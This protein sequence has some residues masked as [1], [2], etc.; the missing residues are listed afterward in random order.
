MPSSR[1]RETAPRLVSSRPLLHEHP[2]QGAT[3]SDAR[4]S[5]PVPC[6]NVARRSRDGAR[7]YASQKAPPDEQRSKERAPACVPDDT[8]RSRERVGATTYRCR[9]GIATVGPMSPRKRPWNVSKEAPRER[10]TGESAKTPRIAETRTFHDVRIR[11]D[12]GRAQSS[13][14]AQNRDARLRERRQGRQRWRAERDGAREEHSRSPASSSHRSAHGV[15]KR[16]PHRSPQNCRGVEKRHGGE[17]ERLGRHTIR[18]VPVTESVDEQKSAARI[19]DHRHVTPG[20]DLARGL[21]R[22]A[23]KGSSQGPGARLV[24]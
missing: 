18:W 24:I 9:S 17:H 7:V 2:S 14:L 22:E 23:R 10:Y 8:A 16:R 6:A 13:S 4:P 1:Q 15:V 11:N 3:E 12:L 19:F 5:M 21:A 20:W